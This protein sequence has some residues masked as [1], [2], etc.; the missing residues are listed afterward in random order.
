MKVIGHFRTPVPCRPSAVR[1]C[2]SNSKSGSLKKRRDREAAVKQAGARGQGDAAT[3]APLLVA[4][5]G[6]SETAR[7][8]R[9]TKPSQRPFA[10]RTT[11]ANA[12]YPIVIRLAL[13]PAAAVFTLS[14]RS[15]SRRS[16]SRLVSPRAK[17]C[18][19]TIAPSR[20]AICSH[21]VRNWSASP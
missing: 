19:D 5:R 2:D 3:G 6:G 4:C 16:S 9:R 10:Q 1:L 20:A 14:E 13:P 18:T 21:R 8:I 15:I 11:P 12:P 7:L 17:P